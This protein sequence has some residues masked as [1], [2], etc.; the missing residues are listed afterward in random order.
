MQRERDALRARQDAMVRALVAD[1]SPPDDFGAA[2][3]VRARRVLKS[4]AAWVA[5]RRAVRGPWSQRLSA[6][7]QSWWR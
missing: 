1:A 3:L 4:K 5:A 2:D 6:W 7:W